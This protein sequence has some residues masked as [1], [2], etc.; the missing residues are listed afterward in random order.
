MLPV[1]KL[2]AWKTE[3]PDQ[4][5]NCK[6]LGYIHSIVR[7]RRQFVAHSLRNY[8]ATLPDATPRLQSVGETM[9]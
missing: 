5:L 8:Y 2:R 1:H 4:A 6:L 9:S 3:I 7:L